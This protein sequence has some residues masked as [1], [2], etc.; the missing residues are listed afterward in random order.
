MP[1]PPTAELRPDQRDEDDLPPYRILDGIL[2]EL[3]EKNA[4][5]NDLV[6]RGFDR[7]TVADVLKRY[8][9]SEYKRR[10]LPPAIKVSAKAFGSGRMMPITHRYRG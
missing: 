9:R 3:I 8:Y 7:E 5:R 2:K 4:S 1:G 10:Q 6:E